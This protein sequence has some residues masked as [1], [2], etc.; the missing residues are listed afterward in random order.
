MKEVVWQTMQS[1]PY[2]REI[3]IQDDEGRIYTCEYDSYFGEWTIYDG[4]QNHP[5]Y[6]LKPIAWAEL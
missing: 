2:D 1:V 3:H 6:R 4:H 5:M